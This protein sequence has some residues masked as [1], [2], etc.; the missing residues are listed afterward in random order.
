MR[1]ISANIHPILLLSFV[2]FFSFVVTGNIVILQD[3]TGAA[4]SN[5]YVGFFSI[6]A[7]CVTMVGYIV[8]LADAKATSLDCN[9]AAAQDVTEPI[10]VSFRVTQ[11]LSG[12]SLSEYNSEPKLNS[13]ILKDE[14]AATMSGVLSS[15]IHN[16]ELKERF[17]STG[18][19]KNSMSLKTA[20][21]S[22]AL[23]S[24]S[25]IVSYDIKGLSSM[26]ANALQA[27]LISAVECVSFTRRIHTIA[28]GNNI[29][30]QRSQQRINHN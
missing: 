15:D 30:P 23:T 26:T 17:T 18:G 5:W 8:T 22:R 21:S 24:S 29:V 14:I 1:Y 2:A 10:M 6:L 27:R 16:I 20:I 11:T 7:L 19:S 3:S 28:A 12:I 13:A 4:K 9:Q 25:I